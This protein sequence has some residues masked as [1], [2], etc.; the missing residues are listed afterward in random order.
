MLV[1]N[2]PDR[3]WHYAPGF[4]WSII[5]V[6]TGIICACLPTMR[7]F[8]EAALCSRFAKALGVLSG[9]ATAEHHPRMAPRRVSTIVL[10]CLVH[11]L[12][13]GLVR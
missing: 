1:L 7:G 3:T 4:M 8:L 11:E 13:K 5:E 6:S 10:V 2:E 12:G 9:G